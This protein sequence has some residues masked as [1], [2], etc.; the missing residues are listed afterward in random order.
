MEFI[1]WSSTVCKFTRPHCAEFLSRFSNI[2]SGD[3]RETKNRRKSFAAYF[4]QRKFKEK[5]CNRRRR[6][7][8]WKEI[9]KPFRYHLYIIFCFA[10][11]SM[12]F[13]WFFMVLAGVQ[14]IPSLYGYEFSEKALLLISVGIDLNCHRGPYKIYQWNNTNLFQKISMEL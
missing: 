4:G 1:V 9:T 7:A 13:F 3:L 8:G 11:K 2:S 14:N 6:G 5:C 10:T 12:G